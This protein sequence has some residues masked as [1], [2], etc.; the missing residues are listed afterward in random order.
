MLFKSK[1]QALATN[2]IVYYK[3]NKLFDLFFKKNNIASNTRNNIDVVLTSIYYKSNNEITLAWSYQDVAEYPIYLAISS[4]VCNDNIYVTE[5][6]TSNIG[7]LDNC[8]YSNYEL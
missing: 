4:C 3:I 6:I 5:T 2:F 1:Y 7:K 8:N